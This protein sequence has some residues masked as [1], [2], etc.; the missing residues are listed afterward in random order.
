MK[1]SCKD[2]ENR[3]IEFVETT[4]FLCFASLQILF[5][6]KRKPVESKIQITILEIKYSNSALMP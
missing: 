5:N 6:I 1:S 2:I 4:Q 3:K